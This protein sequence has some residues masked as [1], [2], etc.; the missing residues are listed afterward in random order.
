MARL[1]SWFYSQL[2]Q[3]PQEDPYTDPATDPKTWTRK[4]NEK[5]MKARGQKISKNCSALDLRKK[6]LEWLA[7]D[8][9]PP[10][11]EKPN[12]DSKDV[13]KLLTSLT[14]MCGLVMSRVVTEEYLLELDFHIK[15]FLTRFHKFSNATTTKELPGWIS[16]HNFVCLLNLPRIAREY[17]PL[18][19]LWE[20]GYLGEGFIRTVKP[21]LKTG[22]RKNWATNLH[23]NV[24]REKVLTGCL[25][26]QVEKTSKQKNHVTY[27]TR[28]EVESAAVRGEVLS[29]LKLVNGSLA[30][31]LSRD[32]MLSVD[33]EHCCVV[34]K[35][36]YFKF[37][38][39][40]ISCLDRINV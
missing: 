22:F 32:R 3:L 29:C 27:K 39:L 20:G 34:N 28:A 37:S 40:Q 19:N 2:D 15:A 23:K 8:N 26:D 35:V 12:I 31:V 1:N 30:F 10:I 25:R 9:P 38:L 24:L 17:G 7:H 6:V 16:S 11:V 33:L 18:R 14:Q 5:W 13:M 21:F 4:Q 36:N